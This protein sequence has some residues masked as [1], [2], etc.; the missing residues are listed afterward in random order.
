M[1]TDESLPPAIEAERL[2]G[3][4]GVRHGFFTRRG[5]VSGGLYESLNCGLGSG[6]DAGAVRENRR[7]A[8]RALGADTDRLATVYQVHGT[9]VSVIDSHWTPSHPPEADGMVTDRTG[10]AL[11]ILTADCA[12][13]LM[14]DERAS[15]IGACHAGWRGALDGITDATIAAMERLGARRDRIRAAIGPCIAQR[16]YQVG[17]EFRDRFIEADAANERYF[18]RDRENRFRFD[19]SSYVADRL[20]AAA[21]GSVEWV[22]GDTYADAGNLFSYRRSTHRGERDYGRALSAIMLC[23]E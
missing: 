8:A 4:G 17:D 9:T 18:R 13:V 16:S 15:V 12:P 19:L 11:G 23:P 21:L 20:T 7:R 10:V 2:A 1:T 5:G 22:G 3:L 6:D 14:A